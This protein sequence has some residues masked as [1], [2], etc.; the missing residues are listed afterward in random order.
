MLVV[1][2]LAVATSGIRLIQLQGFDAN[3]YAAAAERQLTRK[4]PL[5]AMRGTITDRNGTALAVSEAAVAITCDPSLTAPK[6]D[7]IAERIVAHVGGTKED[8]LPALTKENTKFAYVAKKVPAAQFQ[9]L[10]DEL[11]KE[12]IYGI[13]RESDPLR[14]YPEGDTAAGVVGFLNAENRG[15]GGLEYALEKQ[16]A[17]EAGSEVFES[18]PA[19]LRIPLGSNVLTPATNGVNY[20]LTIDAELQAMAEEL[21]KRQQEDIGAES[22]TLITMN[23][24]TGEVLAMV[25]TPSFDSNR[26]AAARAEDLGNRAVSQT[27]EPGSVQKILTMAALID[28]GTMSPDTRLVLPP[29]IESGGGRVTDVWD[30]GY[31]NA[32]AT[33]VMVHSSNIGTIMLARQMEKAQYRQ[34]LYEFGIG[35][36]TGIE[37]PG[38][39][40]GYLPAADMP[41]ATRDQISFGQG[42]STTA[43]QTTAAVAGILN[44]GVYNQPTIIKS[45]TDADGNPVQLPERESRRVVSEETSK[46]VAGLMEAVIGPGGPKE[47]GMDDYRSGGKTGTAEVYQADKGKYEG[48]LTSFLGAAPVED[49]QIVTYVSFMYP[50]TKQNGAHS[51]GP[52]YRD[53]TRAALKRFAVQPSTTKSPKYE[54]E[55]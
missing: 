45:A 10:A 13:F 1:L 17:G 33:G 3:S 24:K 23:V 49:P 37:L 48:L 55:W 30:H 27:Y 44:G 46:E 53:V 18:S 5:P 28:G 21:M 36:P 25:N 40:A 35:R 38:E 34:Y 12:G 51:A 19:G 39:A 52:V 16:L 14:Y 4:V 20:Q 7:Y 43:L 22:G 9:R 42:F 41:D 54:L 47:L 31:T 26:T 50:K 8:Y 6:A 32:T 15:G 2:V 29:S 11:S